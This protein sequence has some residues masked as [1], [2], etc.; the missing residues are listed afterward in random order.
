M[1]AIET[2]FENRPPRS[3]Y[4]ERS[5]LGSILLNSDAFKA[6]AVLEPSD[7]LLTQHAIIFAAYLELRESGR[8]IDLVVLIDYLDARGKLDASGGAAY[9]SGLLDGI[10]RQFNIES[11]IRSVLAASDRREL[12]ALGDGLY[13]NAL[14]SSLSPSQLLGN[15]RKALEALSSRLERGVGAENICDIS[16]S[17]KQLFSSTSNPTEWIVP[18]IVAAGTT[19]LLFGKVKQ[20]GKT[21]FALEAAAAITSGR[22]FL[23]I[24]TRQTDVVY[25]SEQG[26]GSFREAIQR[27]GLQASDSLHIVFS[28]RV[29]HLPWPLIVEKSIRH[30]KQHD[31]RLLVVDTISQFSGIEGDDENNA[32]AAM[33]AMKPLSLAAADGGIGILILA[34]ERKSGGELGDSGRGSS[35]FAGAADHLLSLR[36]PDG[37]T[38]PTL[39]TLRG[40]GRTDGLVDRL[41]VEL[42]SDGYKSHGSVTEVALVEAGAAIL[43]NL[44]RTASDALPLARIVGTI[45]L[46]RTTAQRALDALMSTGTV[47][48]L[49]AGTKNDGFRFFITKKDSAQTPHTNGQKGI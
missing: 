36:R 2:G 6:A 35:A 10:P 7:F 11:E 31:A 32:G 25:L 49:G 34:H 22:S 4:C 3:L 39:R 46:S 23:G 5:I 24:P 44:P 13:K 33:A 17:A 15:H 20:A 30:C 29:H 38:R 28:H 9:V 48:R 40:L 18:G 37:N 27:A 16:C 19:S 42:T 45:G 26:P 14:D 47:A 1:V 43:A 21:T 8:A 12:A 41:T